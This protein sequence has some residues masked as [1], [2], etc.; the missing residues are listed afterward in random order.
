MPLIMHLRHLKVKGEV[1]Q[2]LVTLPANFTKRKVWRSQPDSDHTTKVADHI[3]GSSDE[4]QLAHCMAMVWSHPWKWA[5]VR[6]ELKVQESRQTK[7]ELQRQR[8]LEERLEHDLVH[9]M[10]ADSDGDETVEH[11]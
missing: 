5:A 3:R 1:K 7:I 4:R 9:M 8:R 6:E 11:D 2:C 10:D